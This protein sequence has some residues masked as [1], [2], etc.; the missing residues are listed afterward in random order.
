MLFFKSLSLFTGRQ[1]FVFLASKKL[2]KNT[3]YRPTRFHLF[4]LQKPDYTNSVG[5]KYK[6]PLYYQKTLF[7]GL[8][9]FVFLASKKLTKKHFLKKKAYAMGFG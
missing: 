7:T 8:Q 4:G 5:I 6:V 1:D 3:F 2:T 9:D